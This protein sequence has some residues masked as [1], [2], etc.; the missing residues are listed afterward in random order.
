MDPIKEIAAGGQPSWE[1]TFDH[2]ELGKL[3][4]RCKR[5][6]TARQWL[7]QAI[8]QDNLQAGLV[9]LPSG[10]TV[11]LAAAIASMQTIIECPV[12]REDRRVDPDNPDHEWIEQTRY[13]PLNDPDIAFITAVYLDFWTWRQTLLNR[14]E[15]VGKSSGETSGEGSDESLPPTMDS[16]ST[17]HASKSGQTPTT[18]GSSLT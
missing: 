5:M 8:A 17:T 11:L 3:T 10:A 12:I 15:E 16:P 4:F 18:S 7:D 1:N 6:P 2:S 13:D 14:V 9:A